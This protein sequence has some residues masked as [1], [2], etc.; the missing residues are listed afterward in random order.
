MIQEN[1]VFGA[2]NLAQF[3]SPRADRGIFM[4]ICKRDGRV[5]EFNE[6]K[7]TDAIFKAAQAVGGEDRTLAME[8]TLDVLKFLRQKFG[9]QVFTVEDVQDCVEK[10]LIEKGHARTAKAYILYRAHRNRIRDAKLC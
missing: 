7:I 8:L 3:R 6:N 4:A 5:V 2:S 1:D 9:E 10:V